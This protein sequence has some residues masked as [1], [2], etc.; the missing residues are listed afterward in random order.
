MRKVGGERPRTGG[1][2][3]A[4]QEQRGPA[5]EALETPGQRASANPARRPPQV[6][7]QSGVPAPPRGGTQGHAAVVALVGARRSVKHG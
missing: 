7:A 1:V 5:R 4:V 2:V 3:G 6:E